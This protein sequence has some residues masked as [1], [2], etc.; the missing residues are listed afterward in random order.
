[1][2]KKRKKKKRGVIFPFLG[3]IA[4]LTTIGVWLFGKKAEGVV[5]PENGTTPPPP[6][7]P[8]PVSGCGPRPPNVSGFGFY[9]FQRSTGRIG[10]QPGTL[11]R[12]PP[13]AIEVGL[14]GRS[15]ELTA[16]LECRRDAGLL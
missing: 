10:Y 7:P 4:S 8:D 5:E 16:W 3:A 2:P 13:G 15:N 9:W 12:F 1:M 14:G 11:R 6:P